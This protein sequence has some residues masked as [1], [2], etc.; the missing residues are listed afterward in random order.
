MAVQALLV[1]RVLA[2]W[3]ADFRLC[4]SPR[5]NTTIGHDLLVWVGRRAHPKKCMLIQIPNV[6]IEG[7][8]NCWA[9]NVST[10]ILRQRESNVSKITF[11]CAS[12][13][14]HALFYVIEPRAVV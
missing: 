5:V 6:H 3:E 1:H 13:N 8:G 2:C 4:D 11:F 9:E 14:L 7:V 12:K 10:E